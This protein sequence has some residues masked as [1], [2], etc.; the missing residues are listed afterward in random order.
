MKLIHLKKILRK[1]RMGNFELS[2]PLEQSNSLVFVGKNNWHSYLAKT[3]SAPKV[4]LI[5]AWQQDDI[6]SELIKP[7]VKRLL[8]SGCGYF[9]CAGRASENLHDFIDNM[10]LDM[11]VDDM[12]LNADKIITTWHDTDTDE[13]VADFFLHSTNVSNGLL[14][15][16]LD[17]N[18]TEDKRLKT[19]ILSLVPTL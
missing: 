1:L 17:E 8:G 18:R 2:V 14:L 10:I 19:A 3:K 11:S 13:E 6:I 9:V 16:F 15:A 4:V 12:Q 7:L 5:T